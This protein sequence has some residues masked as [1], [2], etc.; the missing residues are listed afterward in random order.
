VVF[1]RTNELHLTAQRPERVRLGAEQLAALDD[2]RLAGDPAGR[3]G[4][5]EEHGI[6]EI[7]GLADTLERRR[8]LP[9]VWDCPRIT[10]SCA[11]GGVA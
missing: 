11:S 7:Q 1:K 4:C 5:Q 10:A 3:I 6:R 2:R 9:D 8:G